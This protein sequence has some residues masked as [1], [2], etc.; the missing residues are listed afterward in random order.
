[1]AFESF[2]H[3]YPWDGSCEIRGRSENSFCAE[4]GSAVGQ[5]IVFADQ[6]S[7]TLVARAPAVVAKTAGL[8]TSDAYRERIERAATSAGM[9]PEMAREALRNFLPLLTEQALVRLQQSGL[10]SSPTHKSLPPRCIFH[11]FA[12]NLFLSGWESLVHAALCGSAN[13]VR[14]AEVD[15]L[16]PGVWQEA[17][18]EVDPDFARTLMVGWWPHE[19]TSVTRMATHVSDATVAFG[20]D[21]SVEAIRALAPPSRR[22]VPHAARV[23][24]A[25][26][27]PE[28]LHEGTLAR[29][30]ELLAYDF[31]VYDQQGCLSP[32][33]AFLL[34]SDKPTDTI[35][36]FAEELAGHMRR[37]AERLPRPRLS[38]EDGAAQAREREA[39]L[40]LA[41]SGGY[42][43]VASRPDDP[44]LVTLRPITTYRPGSL[45]R[46]CDLRYVSSPDCVPVSER[47]RIATLGVA[48]NPENWLDWAS[49]L[50]IPR[51]CKV[52]QMQ[53]PPLGWAHDGYTALADI[54]E[55]LDLEA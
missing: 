28:A 18:R 16:F 29:T 23:S 40:V 9:H 10:A 17:L 26:I 25:V 39:T 33:A 30:A 50:R 3:G 42:G 27:E 13:I 54:V 21:A 41:A 4:L 20:S 49:R 44:F 43:L 38:L 47:G 32:R 31:S 53:R 5:M 22:F 12:G 7:G 15:P 46:F 14:C 37:I 34:G 8:L 36:H 6:E 48:G 55:R 35:R 2:A 51:I 19:W 45:N 11:V 1:M 24:Y 52:G